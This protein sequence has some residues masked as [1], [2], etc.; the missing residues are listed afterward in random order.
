M[1]R[2]V[3]AAVRK[4]VKMAIERGLALTSREIGCQQ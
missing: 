1:E 4:R 2:G 3:S